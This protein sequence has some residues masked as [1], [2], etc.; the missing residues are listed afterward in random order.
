MFNLT[1]ECIAANGTGNITSIFNADTGGGA[2]DDV[3]G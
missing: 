3:N 2:F 1:K